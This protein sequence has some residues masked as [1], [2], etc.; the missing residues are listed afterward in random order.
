MNARIF[1]LTAL[2]FFLPLTKGWAESDALIIRSKIAVYPYVGPKEGFSFEH[3][4]V[5][6][7]SNTGNLMAEMDDL[8]RNET[9]TLSDHERKRLK[10]AI[11]LEIHP[12]SVEKPKP[13]LSQNDLEQISG[14]NA[15]LLEILSGAITHNPQK[16][17]YTINSQIYSDVFSD[18]GS[19]KR[20][21]LMEDSNQHTTPNFLNSHHVALLY[22][23]AM[24]AKDR[25][26]PHWAII[27]L[28]SKAQELSE[29]ID[30]TYSAT[31]RKLKNKILD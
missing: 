17:G 6:L 9:I 26:E 7:D 31:A 2:I 30:L 18:L 1:I 12:L 3:F 23:M 21:S 13:F 15:R 16:T 29:N 5:F 27:R 4:L 14:K 11:D 20:V 28:L 8:L 24:D 22:A 25:E 10:E 19:K